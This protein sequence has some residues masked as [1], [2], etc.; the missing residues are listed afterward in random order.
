MV[1]EEVHLLLPQA[2]ISI[3]QSIAFQLAKLQLQRNSFQE[4][5]VAATVIKNPKIVS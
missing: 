4:L 3:L 2:Q 1:W 5:L